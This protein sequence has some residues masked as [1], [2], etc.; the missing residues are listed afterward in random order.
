MSSLHR[1]SAAWMPAAMTDARLSGQ[2]RAD[3]DITNQGYQGSVT[4]QGGGLDSGLVRVNGMNGVIPLSGR[5]GHALTSDGA[6]AME[7]LD[8]R[9]SSEDAYDQFRTRV[10]DGSWDAEERN[11][12]RVASLRYGP[13]EIR[14][15]QASIAQS[16]EGIVARRFAFRL[17]DGWGGGQA[18]V[19]PLRGRIA[20]TLLADGLS[21]QAICDAF[22]AIKGYISGRVNGLAE[23]SS[24]QFA[25]DVA[26]GRARFWAVRSR[27]ERNEISRTLIE[28]LAGRHIK[29]FSLFGDDRR[30]DRGVL[31]VSLKSG[32][33]VFHEL[34][35]SHSTLGVKDL[36]VK[37]SSDF[38]R[39]NAA[40]LLDTI[41]EA[42]K[43]VQASG[44]PKP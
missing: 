38:N 17:W 22:P 30:Y 23:F 26:Q 8:S 1:L 37:V 41:I 6:A 31:D 35:I 28:K 42:T 5:V 39:I 18:M 13:I 11:S 14:D 32:D 7:R 25:L 40:H 10:L 2:V 34:D 9:L 16:G 19:E 12:L 4:I 29:Y 36:D 20:L 43:R 21:L 44:T 15:L 33:L 24:Q 3:L 27:K